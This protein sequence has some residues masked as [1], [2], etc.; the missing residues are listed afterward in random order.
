M[1]LYCGTHNWLCVQYNVKSWFNSWVNSF[2]FQ[3][4][5]L[6]HTLK[7]LCVSLFRPI[8]ISYLHFKAV[9]A[10]PKTACSTQTHVSISFIWI[11][12]STLSIYLCIRG[13]NLCSL[14]KNWGLFLHRKL[15]FH[16]Y[17][18]PDTGHM[19]LATCYWLHCLVEV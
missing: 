18:E 10:L 15:V 2:T 12:W 4:C 3:V 17:F 14:K 19:I 11:V 13:A 8:W 6:P 5:T 1:T 9:L 7:Y 16:W